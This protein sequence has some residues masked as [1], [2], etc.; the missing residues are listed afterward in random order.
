LGRQ[1]WVSCLS[2]VVVVSSCDGIKMVIQE[3]GYVA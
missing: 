2:N 3:K 1:E